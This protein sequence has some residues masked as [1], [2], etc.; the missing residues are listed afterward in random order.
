MISLGFLLAYRCISGFASHHWLPR[1]DN[2][3]RMLTHAALQVHDWMESSGAAE[4]AS[5]NGNLGLARGAANGMR[6]VQGD[7]SAAEH[8]AANGKPGVGLNAAKGMHGL[9]V[10][11]ASGSNAQLAAE[12][13]AAKFWEPGEPRTAHY[14]DPDFSPVAESFDVNPEANDGLRK[15]PLDKC[16]FC[17]K[18]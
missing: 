13:A 8:A 10:D 16:V 3:A 5:A 6:G 17:P 14:F 11:A 15:L 7:A 18:H 2:P 9:R 1:V 4:P 12:V